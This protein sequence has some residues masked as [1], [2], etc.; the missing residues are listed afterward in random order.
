MRA[1]LMSSTIAAMTLVATVAQAAPLSRQEVKVP[2]AFTVN[3]QQLPAG[4]Y[5]V[6]TDDEQSSTLLIQGNHEAVY[7]LTAPMSGGS[8]AQDTSLVF[9]KDGDRYRL[10]QVWNEDGEGVSIVGAK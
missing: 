3:G 8:A 1:M 4:T 7:V 6:S 9:A 10:T 2:F 5:S